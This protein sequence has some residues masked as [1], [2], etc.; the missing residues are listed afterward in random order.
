MHILK[1]I[2]I[3]SCVLTATHVTQTGYWLDLD[4]QNYYAYIK[5][6][7]TTLDAITQKQTLRILHKHSGDKDIMKMPAKKFADVIYILQKDALKDII[8]TLSS[9]AVNSQNKSDILL[10]S[11]FKNE[12]YK[13]WKQT[14]KNNYANSLKSSDWA[15]ILQSTFF[16]IEE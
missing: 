8:Q 4:Y 2:I 9:K 3:A 1:Q 6:A 15:W 14:F 10:H 5:I 16:Y 13:Q 7:E 11:L 12:I